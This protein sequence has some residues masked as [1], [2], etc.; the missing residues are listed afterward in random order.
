VARQGPKPPYVMVRGSFGVFGMRAFR[1]VA[2]R[3]GTRWVLPGL[4]P[5]A[6]CVWLTPDPAGGAQ[7]TGCTRSSKLPST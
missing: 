7:W 6:A 5:S 2:M 4:V 3:L 1:R